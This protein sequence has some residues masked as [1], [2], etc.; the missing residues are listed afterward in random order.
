MKNTQCFVPNCGPVSNACK[1]CI[2]LKKLYTIEKAC[3]YDCICIVPLVVNI[4][5]VIFDIGNFL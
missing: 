2:Q 5:Y 3:W 1:N 4:V